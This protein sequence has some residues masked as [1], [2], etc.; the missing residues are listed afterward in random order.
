MPS[1]PTYH[2]RKKRDLDT[3]TPVEVAG[4]VALNLMPFLSEPFLVAQ[5]DGKALKAMA[6]HVYAGFFDQVARWAASVFFVA[7]KRRNW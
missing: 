6:P 1:N 7:Q 2:V 5:V 3:F 4:F